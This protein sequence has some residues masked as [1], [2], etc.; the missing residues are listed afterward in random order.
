[1]PIYK[2]EQNRYVGKQFLKIPPH[3]LSYESIY[4]YQD[5]D[6]NGLIEGSPFYNPVKFKQIINYSGD[7]TTDIEIP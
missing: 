7:S 6:I 5:D 3:T 2:N 4:Y 1:M